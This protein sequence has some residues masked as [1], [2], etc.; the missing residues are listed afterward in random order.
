MFFAGADQCFC[1]YLLF[2]WLS[3]ERISKASGVHAIVR[4]M[5]THRSHK[6]LQ[7]SALGALRT[8]SM[9]HECKATIAEKGITSVFNA[10]RNHSG[11]KHVQK[12]ACGTLRNLLSG[13]TQNHNHTRITIETIRSNRPHRELELAAEC[14][15]LECEDNAFFCLDRINMSPSGTAPKSGS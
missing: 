2:G 7:R 10:M 15:P 14:F 1:Y 13:M 8:L 11:D 9:D 4:G 6:N 3:K 12:E 5:D